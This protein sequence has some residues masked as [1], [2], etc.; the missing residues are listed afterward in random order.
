MNVPSRISDLPAA[1]E[2]IRRVATQEMGRQFAI[3]DELFSKR[4]WVADRWSIAD[5]YLWWVWDRAGAYGL[6]RSPYSNFAAHAKR[7]EQRPSVQRALS[8]RFGGQVRFVDGLGAVS[9]IG[10][11][12]NASYANVRAG[13]SALKDAGAEPRGTSTSSF[14]ITWMLPDGQV[15]AAVRAL[16]ARFI[17]SAAPLVP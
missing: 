10:A 9:V 12:I 4:E 15:P 8:A 16:H 13:M 3:A 5:T 6:D 7:V 14:R 11:G 1:E 2:S 17:E